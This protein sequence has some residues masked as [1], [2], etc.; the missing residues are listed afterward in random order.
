M[1]S[2]PNKFAHFAD[3]VWQPLPC[4]HASG[5]PKQDLHNLIDMVVEIVAFHDWPGHTFA[6]ASHSIL[7][8]GLSV[9]LKRSQR[10]LSYFLQKASKLSKASAGSTAPTLPRKTFCK[11]CLEQELAFC[12]P[13]LQAIAMAGCMPT[14]KIEPKKISMQTYM[15]KLPCIK[16][17]PSSVVN[18]VPG[19]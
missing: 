3:T 18:N 6:E 17:A 14:C 7:L 12:C 1:K 10:K 9:T 8:V 16:L 15:L 19:E 5:L 2:R 13:C 11:P 4:G